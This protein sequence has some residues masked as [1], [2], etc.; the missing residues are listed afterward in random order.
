MTTPLDMALARLEDIPD[1]ELLQVAEQ[2]QKDFQE[3]NQRWG[4]CKAE[5]IKR[6]AATEAS[7]IDGG[8]ILCQIEWT[9]DYDWD[10]ATVA[11][12]A[13]QYTSWTEERVIPAEQK[14]K[15]TRGLNLYIKKLGNT[16][17]AI[18]L[19][20]ARRVVE[21]NPRFIFMHPISGED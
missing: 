17:K 6:A 11:S 7:V 20:S 12:E 15:D 4:R 9:K 2:L 19:L 3:A 13:P 8:D 18:R 5:M 10:V 21:K 16:D 14:V 1:H